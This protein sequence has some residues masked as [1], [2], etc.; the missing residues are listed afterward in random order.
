M[1]EV[2]SQAI[3]IPD[4]RTEGQGTEEEKDALIAKLDELLERY[5]NTLDEYERVRQE[6]SKQLSSVCIESLFWKAA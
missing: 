1:A 3:Q 2:H 5:L 4:S 6:L